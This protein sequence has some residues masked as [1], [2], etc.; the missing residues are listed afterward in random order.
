MWRINGP[1]INIFNS[2]NAEVMRYVGEVSWV[3]VGG[4]G[5]EFDDFLENEE[6][7]EKLLTLRLGVRVC[8]F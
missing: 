1:F 4:W 8:V 2:Y 3:C 7:E 5:G 6:F